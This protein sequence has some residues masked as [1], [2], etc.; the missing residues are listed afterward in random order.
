MFAIAKGT[1]KRKGT[2]QRAHRQKQKTKEKKK[3]KE[4]GRNGRN[5]RRVLG[6]ESRIGD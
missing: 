3:K 1:A 2:F 5:K 6:P 4:K